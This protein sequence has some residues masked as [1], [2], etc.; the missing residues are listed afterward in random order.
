MLHPKGSKV[1]CESCVC[2]GKVISGKV[3]TWAFMVLHFTLLLLQKLHHMLFPARSQPDTD[4]AP[5]MS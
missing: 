5:E 4:T 2:G 1:Q 3:I